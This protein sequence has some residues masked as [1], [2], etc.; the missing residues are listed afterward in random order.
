MK[1]LLMTS[2]TEWKFYRKMYDFSQYDE[3]Q[4]QLPHIGLMAQ[5]ILLDKFRYSKL[6]QYCTPHWWAVGKPI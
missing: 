6:E 2:F 3:K 1:N 4:Q 5:A